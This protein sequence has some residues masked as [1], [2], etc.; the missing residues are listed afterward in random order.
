[1]HCT[2]LCI[3][4]S[5]YWPTSKVEKFGENWRCFHQMKSWQCSSARIFRRRWNVAIF[6]FQLRQD[7]KGHS[8]DHMGESWFIHDGLFFH[9]VNKISLLWKLAVHPIKANDLKYQRQD[10]WL[11]ASLVARFASTSASHREYVDTS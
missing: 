4:L 1:M 8:A 2:C 7:V 3:A 9:M 5:S 11:T 6:F 10:G